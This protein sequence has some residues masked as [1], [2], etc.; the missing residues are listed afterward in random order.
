MDFACD[1]SGYYAKDFNVARFILLLACSLRLVI[2][3]VGFIVMLL[4]FPKSIRWLEKMMESRI[5]W[6]LRNLRTVG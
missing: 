2:F 4:I 1:L 3:L 5:A 6:E